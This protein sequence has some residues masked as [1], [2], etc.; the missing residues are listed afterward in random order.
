VSD[1][2]GRASDAG[3]RRAAHSCSSLD[4]SVVVVDHDDEWSKLAHDEARRLGEMLSDAVVAIEH[5]GSTAV[6]G[7][8]SK[9]VVDLA[10]GVSDDCAFRSVCIALEADGYRAPTYGRTDG[11]YYTSDR[12]GRCVSVHVLQ[13]GGSSWHELLAMR[14]Y[15]RGR[16]DEAASY[17]AEKRRILRDPRNAHPQMYSGG[18]SSYV[19]RLLERAMKYRAEQ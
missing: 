5:V 6:A 3:E 14:D 12:E 9:P 13:H 15:L 16:P 10:V 1:S 2:E 18:K 8:P 19:G 11:A 17:G 4:A 7:L